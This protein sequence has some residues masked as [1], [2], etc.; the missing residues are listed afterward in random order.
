MS[1]KLVS[2]SKDYLEN[3]VGSMGF[4]YDKQCTP[5]SLQSAI[6]AGHL[7]L[8]EHSMATFDI[9]CSLAVLGQIT[10]HRHLS[11]TVKSTRGADFDE[12]YVPEDIIGKNRDAMDY[13]LEKAVN[14]YQMLIDRGVPMESAAYLL[15]KATITKLR[16]SGNLRAW[17]EYLPKRLCKRALPEHMQIAKRIHSELT[18]A[19]PEIFDRN[20][21]NCDSCK[22]NGCKF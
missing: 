12:F 9:E 3:I 20:F 7:S 6:S 14:N 11:F 15:P 16:V 19:I 8:L 21:M 18:L 2:F 1:V 22:E 5:K 17:F 13:H 4:C 10:R